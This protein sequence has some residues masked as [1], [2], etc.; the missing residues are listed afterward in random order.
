[1]NPAHRRSVDTDEL[2]QDSYL[3]TV[4]L[5]H[6]ARAK[7]NQRLRDDCIKQV[8]RVCSAL[9]EAKVG[10]RSINLITHA[11]CALLDEAALTCATGECRRP[12]ESEPLQAKFFHEHQAGEKLYENIREVL[13]EAAPDPLVLTVFHR[14]LLL[15][16]R[17]RYV[18]L[19]DPAREQILAAL[20]ALVTPMDH[21]IV[22]TD[23]VALDHSPQ[24]TRWLQAPWFHVASAGALLVALWWGLDHFLTAAIDGLMLSQDGP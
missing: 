13:S 5:L 7:E 9:E 12:W 6:G 23:A 4:Q 11:Q 3:L 2:L 18:D 17:G 15:G 22:R 19:H 14:V 8:E 10:Q 21:A 20:S 24:S 1:M 16:F